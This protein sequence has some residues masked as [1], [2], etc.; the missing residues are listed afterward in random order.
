MIQPLSLWSDVALFDHW[1]IRGNDGPLCGAEL[2]DTE[3][4]LP[5]E[6]FININLCLDCWERLALHCANTP[7]P[8]T[9]AA[10]DAAKQ[11]EPMSDEAKLM[12]AAMRTDGSLLPRR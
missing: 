2:G 12:I 11:R 10:P 5:D 4:H 8:L 7:S 9:P 6:P 3:W 1:H